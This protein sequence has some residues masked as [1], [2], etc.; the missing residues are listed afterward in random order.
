MISDFF[1]NSGTILVV[2]TIITYY[3][4]IYINTP[5]YFSIVDTL[6]LFLF[7]IPIF[8]YN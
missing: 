5:L 8:Y 4:L 6:S 3:K 7:L 2:M 1:E